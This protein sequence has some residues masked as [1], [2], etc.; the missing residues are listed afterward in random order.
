MRASWRPRIARRLHAV[1]SALARRATRHTWAGRLREGAEIERFLSPAVD[2]TMRSLR[3]L[4]NER[5]D[6]M[7]TYPGLGRARGMCVAPERVVESSASPLFGDLSGFPPLPLSVGE[8]RDAARRVDSRGRTR[9]PVR[10]GGR[11]RDLERHGA[12][13]P[14]AAHGAAGAR[15]E[16]EHRALHREA[17]GMDGMNGACILKSLFGMD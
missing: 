11:A 3:L 12:C 4:T 5:S 9:A 15:R 8:H 7:F 2:L 13:V 10:H 16:R 14:G 1:H 6:P 17:H